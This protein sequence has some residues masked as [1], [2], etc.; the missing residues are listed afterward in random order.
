MKNFSWKSIEFYLTSLFLVRLYG[1]WFPTLETWHSWRQTLTNMMARNMNEHQF[2]FL[3]PEIDMAG[4]KSGIIGSEFPLFQNLI[5]GCNEIFGYDHWYG[6]LIALI[7]STVASW[8]FFRII[9]A[10]WNKRTAW[11]ST[12]VFTCSLWF[13]F[14]RKSM[15]DTF[16]VSLVIIGF[17]FLMRFL[18]ERKN[19]FL[20]FGFL[21]ITLGGLCK[22][23]AVYL[24]VLILP[25]LFQTKFQFKTRLVLLGTIGVASMIIGWWYFIWVPYLVRTYDFELFFPKGIMEGIR[26]IQPYWADFWQQIYFGALRS[27]IA[28]LPLLFGLGWLVIQNNRKYIPY[29]VLPILVFLLFAI[30]TGTVFPT[31]NY[32][33]LPLVPLLAVLVGLGLQRLDNRFA[34]ALILIIAIEGI[35]NQIAD[36]RIKEEVK[37]KLELAKELDSILPRSNK[38][39]LTTGSNP[40]WMY[41]FHRKGWSVTSERIQDSVSLNELTN[42]GA[43]YLVLDHRYD[44]T[45]YAFK[46]IGRRENVIVF[47]MAQKK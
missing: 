45:A 33:V 27:Y 39:V 47:D 21:G 1:I 43:R 12:V 37:Y 44:S 26:E 18:M 31:H 9:E 13:S 38:I 25:F 19:L 20:F 34:L 41:W 22:I 28:L 3:Y 23:P 5:A 36:F 7:S 32:Y 40:E 2:T 17:Y 29:F 15:P 42:E 24:F 35:G 4:A 10:I 16:A 14:S 30:K 8:C 46:E 6:R 11:F